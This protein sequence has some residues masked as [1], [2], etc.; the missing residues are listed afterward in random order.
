M[1]RASFHSGEVDCQILVFSWSVGWVRMRFGE[2]EGGRGGVG[3]DDVRV[4]RYWPIVE[5]RK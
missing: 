4:E 1:V 5:W 3:D 2:V